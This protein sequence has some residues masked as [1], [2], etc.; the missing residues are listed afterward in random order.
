MRVSLKTIADVWARIVVTEPT[1]CWLWTGQTDKDG[2][3]R[4]YFDDKKVRIHRLIWTV[5]NHRQPVGLVCHTC[6][7]PPCCNPF[8]LYD[9]TPTSNALDSVARGRARYTPHFGKDNGFSKLDDQS[10]TDIR[11]L[12]ASGAV[13]REVA[14]LF[15]IS[16]ALV[17]YITTRKYWRHV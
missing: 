4:G 16:K 14:A 13:H 5:V 12:C 7:N 1:E 8:H 15:G 6:D 2:Y 9:G 11:W 10:V 17:S 3:G